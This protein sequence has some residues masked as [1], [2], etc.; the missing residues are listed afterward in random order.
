MQKLKD[1]IIAIYKELKYLANLDSAG[2]SLVVYM[3]KRQIEVMN[4]Y[5]KI[6]PY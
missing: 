4:A 1:V 3:K 5:L 2:I 6:V